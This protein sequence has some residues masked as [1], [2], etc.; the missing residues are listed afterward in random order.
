MEFINLPSGLT[1]AIYADEGHSQQQLFED[2][3]SPKATTNGSN[4]DD[5]GSTMS[6]QQRL[7]WAPDHVEKLTAN[8]QQSMT[9][10]A[11]TYDLCTFLRF[12]I[13]SLS[14]LEYIHKHNVIHGEIRLNAFQWNGSDDGPVKLWNFGSGSKSLESYLTSEGWRK[15]ANNKEL[16]GVLQSLLVYMSPEQTGRTT[17]A[18]DHRTDIYSLGIVFFALLTGKSPFDGGPLEILNGILSRKIPLVHEV[19]FDTPEMIS[20][21]IEK[22]TSKAPDDRYNSAR[23]VRHDLEECLKRLKMADVASVEP[24]IP[25]PLAQNDIASVFTLSKHIYGRQDTISQMQFL[26]ERCSALYNQITHRSRSKANGFRGSIQETVIAE[27]HAMDNTTASDSYDVESNSQYSGGIG[28]GGV[29]PVAL[30]GSDVSSVSSRMFVNNGKTATTLVGVYGPGG[31]G[32]STLMTTVQP[33]A[34]QNGY[35]ATVKFDSRNKVP[36]STIFKAL[37]Q[38]VQQILTESEDAIG[39]FYE[40]LRVSLGPQ[41]CNI[42]LVIDF[43]PELKSLL[44]QS[45]DK[46]DVGGGMTVQVDNIEARARFHKIYVEVFR[47][48][49]HWNMVTLFLDDLHQADDPSLELME[50]LIVSRVNILIFVSYRDQEINTKQTEFLANKAADLHLIKVDPLRMDPLLDF[51]CDT[52][53]RP[54]DVNNREAITPL[55]DIIF[56][57]TNGNVFFATQLIRSLERKKLIYFDWEK[58]EWGFDLCHIEE[59]TSLGLGS[60]LDVSFIVSRLRELP[61]A[62]QSFLKWASY[63][64]DSFSLTTVKN[65]MLSEGKDNKEYDDSKNI[66]N[67][68]KDDGNK[69]GSTST[70]TDHD[71]NTAIQFACP[72]HDHSNSNGENSTADDE[73]DDCETQSSGSNSLLAS[74]THR[75]YAY[76]KRS[77]ASTITSSTSSINDPISGLQAVLQE[78]YIMSLGGD[79]FK[80]SHDRISAAASELADPDARSR[81]HLTIAQ[82]LMDEKVVDT[83][84]V[85]DHLIKCQDILSTIDDKQP[86]RNAMLSAGT[87][88]QSAGA[89]GMAFSYYNVAILLSDTEN[90]WNDD[91]Y[92]TTLHLYTNAVALSWVVGQYDKTEELLNVIFKYAKS[93]IDRLPA[94]RVQAQFYYASQL[95]KEGRETLFKCLDELGDEVSQMDTSDEAL[96]REYIQT[97]KNFENI[98]IEGVLNLEPCDDVILKG[99]VG[100]MDELVVA[101]YWGGR[102]NEAFYWACRV[103]NLSLAKGPTSV[104]GNA[105]MTAA[106][107]Y[108]HVFKKYD[109]AEKLG[110]AGIQLADKHG[111]TLDKGRA[112][113]LYPVFGLQWKYHIKEAFHYF[114]ESMQ[115][116]LSSGDRI[117]NAF[118]LVWI[119]LLKFYTG[120]NINDTVRAAEQGFEEI[121]SWSPTLDHNS[122][123]MCVIR[124]CKA[125]QGK[126][127][128]DTP[129][130]FDGDDGFSDAHFL[131]ES[132]RHTGNPEILL[133][134]YESYKII[135]LVLY[136]HLDSAIETGY[137]CFATIDGHPCHRHTRVMSSYFSLALIEKARLDPTNQKKY[138]D[139]VQKNQALLYGWTI[140]TPINYAMYW[141]LVEAELRSMEKPLDVVKVGELYENAINQAREGSWYLELCVIHEY[142]GSFYDRIGFKNVA[143]GLIKK[144]VDLYT[145]HG[146]YGKARHLN[147]RFAT[148]LEEFED[149]RKE[150]VEASAQTDPIPFQREPTWSTA[151]S[152]HPHNHQLREEEPSNIFTNEPYT[153]E[154]IPAVTAEKTLLSLDI[155]D[156]ASILKSSQVMSSEVKFDNLLTSMLNII[157]ENSGAD[158]GAIIVKDDKYCVN[159][160]GCQNETISTFDPPKPLNE[161]DEFVSSKIVNHTIHTGEGIFIWN[162]A[163][164]PRFAVGPWFQRNGAKS[165]ICMPIIHKCTIAGCLLI[166]GAVGV[167]THRHVTVLGLL[168]QQMGI[169]ITNAFLFKSVQRV[170]MANMRMIEMQKQALEEARKSKEA[171]DRA[172][173]L[174]EIFLA[175]MSHEIRTPFSGF[176]GMISL[177]AETK[178]DPEQH[179]LVYTAKESCEMLLRLIDDLLNFSKLQA[180]KVSLDISPVIVDNAIADVVEMLVAM[181]IKKRINI[182]YIVSPDVPPVVMAD[183]NRLRQV[184]INLLGNAIKFTHYGEILIRCSI[185]KPKQNYSSLKNI[186]VSKNE[187]NSIVPLFFEVI[188][189]GIGISEDQRK[190]LFVPFS[191]V[192]GSTTRKY[193]G[194]GLGLSICM[195]LVTLMSGTIDVKS[196]PLKGSNFHFSINT[197]AVIDQSNK[198]IQLVNGLL[199]ELGNNPIL[200]VDTYES[201]VNMI[202]ELLP[203]KSVDG[204]CSVDQ[205]ISHKGSHYPIV[206]IGF[207]LTHDPEFFGTWSCHLHPLLERAR[208][209]AIMHYPTSSGAM[210]SDTAYDKNKFLIEPNGHDEKRNAYPTHQHTQSASLNGYDSNWNNDVADV[211]SA[212][213]PKT[214]SSSLPISIKTAAGICSPTQ[215]RAIVRVN[216]P[217]RRITFLK[218]LIDTLHQ[219]TASPETPRPAL[220]ARASSEVRKV[221][222]EF[223]TTEERA[224]YSTQALLV[225][226]DNPVAQKLLYKQLT[227]LGFKVACANNGLEAVE[228]WKKHPSNHFKMAFFDHH[229]PK[230]DGVEA[231]KRIRRIEEKERRLRL[232][233]VTLTAD[234]QDSA[235]EICMNAGFDDYLTKPMNHKILAEVLRRYCYE[236][237]ATS[238]PQP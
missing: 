89:H 116:T 92:E 12:A 90:E 112:Y 14:C 167:F 30:D 73:M 149:S 102:K 16:V 136:G 174:R 95:H 204:I 100:V 192:D 179:D 74:S 63:V 227:R 77:M 5:I 159:A 137:R 2:Y 138:M 60:Q 210:G 21:I 115:Y 45:N 216:I 72:V 36:Y 117:Y 87:K 24:I 69:T 148:L 126:T 198:R 225:A 143:Y 195:H 113:C 226:E 144:A 103:V 165:I 71:S 175:N 57:K 80:W 161:A 62:G 236:D 75:P 215:R 205:L 107:G 58:N 23:G 123:V 32:K 121:H 3:F 52:L 29:G 170:T 78:G 158:C 81:M 183:A 53:H 42:Q 214:S 37:S 15:T 154:L 97:E 218:V 146:S 139:Q 190:A 207:Y 162:V 157:F 61:R 4:E 235:K 31:I 203:G 104:T 18:P 22:M 206:I 98:G 83:F 184:I 135:A 141:T 88:G 142:A 133:N 191:Q 79:E 164:D 13:K 153:S 181:V 182:T 101:N 33:T 209:I 202:R 85:A 122:L 180:G 65:L 66:A 111:T 196:T 54:R 43:I 93:P 49:T 178:L 6:E 47:A 185:K 39:A 231:A 17:Y 105:C 46:W 19:Q 171:A 84:L 106:L 222:R 108:G 172:T 51:L 200:V 8:G 27:N 7:Y 163:E 76:R 228:Y 229:M 10:S 120:E 197:S 94:Y 201:S 223:V 233:I 194:T 186:E 131:E 238:A 224:A 68:E 1:V 193:G 187:D 156:M 217:L 110:S 237:K 96:E 152:Q 132:C 134:W 145:C 20:R 177:L 56:R 99:S 199:D 176:Y 38:I 155:L 130:V 232:P 230:C 11:P 208:C 91:E 64:G 41:F 189:S 44:R 40:H 127:Y 151:S 188:D 212:K 55:A 125:L 118:S 26:I 220:A 28:S 86:Y 129:H 147:T 25:F 109:F 128:V 82:Q 50:S 219:T 34:R 173:K 168:C 150:S 234:I 59:A 166:E 114:K 221:S 213:P 140:Q 70:T 67:A 160:Y 169:S 9:G 35:I 211:S 124:I 119:P 48:I